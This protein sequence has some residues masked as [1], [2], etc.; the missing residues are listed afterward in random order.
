LPSRWRA[1][2]NGLRL[3]DLV[4]AAAFHLNRLLQAL[5]PPVVRAWRFQSQGLHL[6]PQTANNRC[7][8][9]CRL[10]RSTL[11]HPSPPPPPPSRFLPLFEAGLVLPLTPAI[12]PKSFRFL[13]SGQ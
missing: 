13:L 6:C 9:I 8:P 7:M 5:E 12:P 10:S 3:P 1:V 2:R 4:V 11:L